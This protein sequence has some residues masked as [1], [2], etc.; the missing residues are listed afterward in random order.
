MIHST[1]RV[2]IQEPSLAKYRVPVFRELANRP[3]IEVFL[4][5]GNRAGLTNVPPDG[6]E[7]QM[8]P[9][10]RAKLGPIPIYW[11]APQITMARK[12]IC[13]VLIYNWN[14]QYLSL[15]PGLLRAKVSGVATI[16]WGHGYSKHERWAK[17]KLRSAIARL[18]DATLFYNQ[19]AASMY[20]EDLGFSNDR[21]FV[22]QN[23]LDQQSITA[24]KSYW[25]NNLATLERF[26]AQQGLTPGQVVLFVS[27]LHPDN[28][29]ELLVQATARLVDRFPNLRTVIVGKGDNEIERLR[30]LA[31]TLQI[32]SRIIFTGPIYD[33]QELGKWF[34]S[35][36][37]FCYP[38]NIGLS[39]LHAFGYGLPVI[40]SD[41]SRRQNPEIEA[42]A[43]GTNGLFYRDGDIEHLSAQIG[44]V[45]GDAGLQTRLSEQAQ[46]TIDQRFNIPAMVDGLESAI[47]FAFERKNG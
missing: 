1:I 45:L 20:I 37:V 44:Q 10:R 42:F 7:G 19:T 40:T 21:V 13:D 23:S 26:Q 8:F 18:A 25:M 15:V 41:D 43:D 34:L 3:G 14:S 5:Y 24:A 11:H 4:A 31:A 9:L 29:L 33:E 12:S 22:A 32:E 38:V 47:R 39:L 35:A 46:Q 36:T 2:A 17:L 30:Q 28:R 6:F 16:C 27:R